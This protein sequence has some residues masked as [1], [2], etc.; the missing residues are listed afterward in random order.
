ML[1]IRY[2]SYHFRS[3]WLRFHD[4]GKVRWCQPDALL[5]D[6]ESGRIVVIEVKYQ[7][8][9]DAWWQLH[10]LYVPVLRE[11]FPATMWTIAVCEVVKWYDPATWFPCR[12]QLLADP[13][14]ARVNEFGVH[15]W[16]K[17]H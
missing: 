16:K 15:I 2:G 3:P 13:V 11:I 7:H 9:L 10:H 1:H 12:V 17:G 5:V 4:N 8:T 6:V 14:E